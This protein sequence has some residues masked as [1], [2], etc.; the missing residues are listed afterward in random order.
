MV[1]LKGARGLEMETIVR[2]LRSE[3]SGGIEG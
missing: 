1:L 3:I 2:A